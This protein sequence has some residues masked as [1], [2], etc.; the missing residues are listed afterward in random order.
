[1]KSRRWCPVDVGFR[2]ILDNP[3]L[4]TDGHRGTFSKHWP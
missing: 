2:S 1:L 4:Q 3:Q